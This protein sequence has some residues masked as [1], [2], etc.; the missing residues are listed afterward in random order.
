MR[1]SELLGLQW[2]DFQENRVRVE[3]QVETAAKKLRKLKGIPENT[4]GAPHLDTAMPKSK[5]VRELD[6]SNE[7]VGFLREHKREQAELKLK[8]RQHY[9]D[10]GLIFAQGLEEK[11]NKNGV[12][13]ERLHDGLIGRVLGELCEACGVKRISPHG[14][15][16]TCASLLLSAGVQPHV[17]QKRL[18][19]SDISMTLGIYAHVLP[20][21]QA[22]AANRLAALLH[23]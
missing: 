10:H 23:R 7:T 14:L 12:L 2:K 9:V 6:L 3:R 11:S 13:G 8:N 15:R 4:S 22:D 1:K 19:H 17:V 21:M 16:H 20:S 5:R 18:G